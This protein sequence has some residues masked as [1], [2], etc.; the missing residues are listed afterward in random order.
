MRFVSM[1]RAVEFAV[2]LEDFG[3]V[4]RIVETSN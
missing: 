1:P 2:E 4:W 3:R